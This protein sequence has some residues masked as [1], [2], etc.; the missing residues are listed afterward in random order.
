MWSTA[1]ETCSYSRA[2]GWFGSPPAPGI[3]YQL[4][5]GGAVTTSVLLSVAVELAQ[6]ASSQR[7]TS[8]LDVGTN[9]IGGLVGA[10]AMLLAIW[11][12][13][14][15]AGRRSFLGIPG[16]LVAGAYAMGAAFEAFIPLFPQDRVPDSQGGPLDRLGQALS[17]FDWGSVADVSIS[18][19]LLVAPAG[20][21]C[22]AALVERGASY[23]LASVR[24]SLAGV[25]LAFG[26]QMMRGCAGE[27]ISAGAILGQ[28]L[29]VGIGALI[30]AKAIPPLS[31][32][33]RKERRVRA[34]YA[35]WT[36]LLVA[37][38]WRPFRAETSLQAMAEKFTV[39]AIVPLVSLGQRVDLFSVVDVARQFVLLL[40]LGALLAVWPV[41]KAG[42]F[43]GALPAVALVFLLELGQVLVAGRLLDVTDPLIGSAGALLGW[44]VIRRSGYPVYGEIG[45]R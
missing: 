28:S 42:L 20:A 26:I 4:G 2:G 36:A 22:V 44:L 8:I 30:G 39:E 34:V 14:G 25:V 41:R 37:W 10:V 17:Y 3:G 45:R 27:T 29:A 9:T 13:Q 21:F 38:A 43:A 15:K 40:P 1:S 31:S 33:L 7:T 24:V 18:E 12:V 32:Y 16:F 19:L 23:R 6:L 5:W 35:V 11:T